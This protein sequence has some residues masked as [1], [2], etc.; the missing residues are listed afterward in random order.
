M[1]NTYPEVCV[2][3]VGMT[4]TI[5]HVL[6]DKRTPAISDGDPPATRSEPKGSL[7]DDDEALT[8]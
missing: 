7:L 1:P 6:P 3:T 4:S 5:V 8:V 2:E